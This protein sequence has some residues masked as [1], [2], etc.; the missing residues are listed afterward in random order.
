MFDVLLLV[1][2]EF[3]VNEAVRVA[4]EYGEPAFAYRVVE[5]LALAISNHLLPTPARCRR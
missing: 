1:L 4:F 3:S 5:L 2:V